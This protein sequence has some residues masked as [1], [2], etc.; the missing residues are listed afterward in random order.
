MKISDKNTAR[1]SKIQED[2]CK[3]GLNY[4]MKV[5]VILLICFEAM[6]FYDMHLVKIYILECN[7]LIY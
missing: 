2:T 3:M 4:T 7:K 1:H 6:Y 5:L